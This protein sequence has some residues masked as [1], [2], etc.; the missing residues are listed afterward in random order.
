[1]TATSVRLVHTSH[2][3]EIGP[4]CA[5]RDEP[6]Q[7]HDQTFALAELRPTLAVGLTPRLGLEL[8]LPFKIHRTTIRYTRLDGTPF[9]LDYPNIHHRNET[10]LGFGDPLLSARAG[11]SFGSVHVSGRLGVSIPLGET[12]ENPFALGEQG[13]EHQHIQFGT[14]TFDP[15]FGLELSAPAGPF[16]LRGQLFASWTLYRNRHGFQA[17]DRYAAGLSAERAFAGG[18]RASLGVQAITELP[19]RWD[20]E[21]QQDGNLGRTDVLVGPSVSLP[22]GAL[23]LTLGVSVPVYQ[24]LVQA[25]DEA[26]QL[27][28][29]ALVTVGIRWLPTSGATAPPLATAGA[30]SADPAR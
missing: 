1:M 9:E 10:L 28:Y 16:T 18:W 22:W 23:D 8:Q 12:E 25:G 2:C 24:R 19:E 21:I 4:I 26:A 6:P 17:G 7:L 3:P 13:L 11:W 5:E 20:G 27:S 30:W 15:S 29:P 14:G